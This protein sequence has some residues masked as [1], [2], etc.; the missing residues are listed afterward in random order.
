MENL[1]V[2]AQFDIA[3][4][5]GDVRRMRSLRGQILANPLNEQFYRERFSYTLSG[6]LALGWEGRFDAARVTLTSI[7]NSET[8]SLPERALLDA[9]LAITA[10]STWHVEL[11]RRAA[12]RTISQTSK[13]ASKE[14]L[15]D[16]RRRRIARILAAAVCIAV[17]DT[18]RGRR[19]LSRSVD[20]EQRFA[21]IIGSDGMRE[22]EAPAMM[23]GY[24]MFFNE[25]CK[26][27]RRARPS[28]HLTEAE[29]E[30]LKALPT[31]MTLATIASSLGKSRKTVERQVGNIYAK[32]HVGNRAQAIQRARDLGIYA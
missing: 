31:G 16:A 32:L 27:A 2:L 15:F 26:A 6:V 21:G 14:P 29:L 7:R 4:E 17:G 28:H 30:V 23:R 10:L 9:L 19:A 20:P 8:L 12:R 24:A 13:R 3:A 5:A 25:A 22:D 11:A 1:G 18:V